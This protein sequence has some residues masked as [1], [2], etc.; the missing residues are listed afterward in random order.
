MNEL[1]IYAP[2]ITNRLKYSCDFAFGSILKL[3]LTYTSSTE[4]FLS[5]DVRVKINYSHQEIKGA[6]Q[7]QPHGLLEETELRDISLHWSEWEG[8]PVFFANRNDQLSFDP[9]A[10]TFFLISRYEEYWPHKRDQFDRFPAAESILNDHGILTTPIVNLWWDRILCLLQE[11]FPDQL[12]DKRQFQVLPTIDVDNAYAFGEKGFVRTLGAYVRSLVNLDGDDLKQRT[13]TL[14]GTK[15]DPFDT[16]DQILAICE[17]YQLKPLFFILLA[18]YGLNDKNVPFTSRKFRSLIKHLHDYGDVG[19]HPGYASN[20]DQN[21]LQKEFNRIANILHRP[22]D[23]SRQHF[24]KVNLPQTYRNL[25]EMEVKEDFSM[26][27]PEEPGYRAGTCTPFHFFDLEFNQKT[28]L[29]LHP[30]AVMEATFRYY[31]NQSPEEAL[32]AIS[33]IIKELKAVKGEFC[34]LWHNDS[35]SEHKDWIGWSTLFEQT[36]QIACEA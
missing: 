29:L 13:A 26:G 32:V 24:L 5:S 12:E 23:K 15:P 30:F 21:V 8:I 31:K 14:L 7:I 18:D 36:L 35:L 10:A 2:N 3:R 27:F 4:E 34:I 19:I 11:Q 17:K 28:P 6:F 33:Q 16:F 9:L 20:F 22:A 25:I 1:V